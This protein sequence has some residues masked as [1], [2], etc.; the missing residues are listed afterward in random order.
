[1]PDWPLRAAAK[2]RICSRGVSLTRKGQVDVRPVEAAQEGR[3]GLAV[4]QAGDDLGPRFLIRRGGEGGQRHA[5][6]RRNSPMRR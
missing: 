6:V 1:M 5:Q 3:G 2:R 4:E